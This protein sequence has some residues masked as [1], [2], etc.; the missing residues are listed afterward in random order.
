MT[1]YRGLLTTCL[2]TALS[3]IA[4][5]P[6]HAQP[7]DG[8][9]SL[10][11]A[12][13][14]KRE[15]SIIVE[16]MVDVF[17]TIPFSLEGPAG[18]LLY[19]WSFPKGVEFSQG[20]MVTEITAAPQGEC[21]ASV[22]VTFVNVTVDWEKK[23]TDVKLTPKTYTRTFFVGDVLPIPPPKKDPPVVPPPPPINTYYF[24]IVRADGPASPEFSKIMADPAWL[25]V[26]KAGHKYK[27]KTKTEATSL[28]RFTIPATLQLP[29]VFRLRDDGTASTVVGNPFPLPTT[30]DGIR[31]LR[32]GE[33]G[34]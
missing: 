6:V 23:T 8:G 13:P 26:A 24:L 9:I 4:I 5:G 16:E 21:K 2:L 28:L 22:S 17:K 12:T 11:G 10:I 15:K 25:D 1:K 27:D 32:G 20:G 29:T 19:T 33:H 30:S 18:G 3:L 31:K 7:K 14:T 34:P